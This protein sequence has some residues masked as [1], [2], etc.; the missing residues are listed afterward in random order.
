ME[1]IYAQVTSY[2]L[3][4]GNMLDIF[5]PD[6]SNTRKVYVMFLGAAKQR[7]ILR[8]QMS[9]IYDFSFRS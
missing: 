4:Q 7:I 2:T 6:S 1:N 5:L 3:E 9:F 8:R